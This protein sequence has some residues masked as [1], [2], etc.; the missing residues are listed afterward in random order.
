MAD[1]REYLQHRKREDAAAQAAASKLEPFVS[2]ALQ[3]GQK[4]A[5]ARGLQLNHSRY[6]YAPF[7]QLCIR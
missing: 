2:R 3:V 6:V 4:L 1:F 7:L 5:A